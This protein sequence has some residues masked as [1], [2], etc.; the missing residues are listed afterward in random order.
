MEGKEE[1][2]K[3]KNYPYCF[4]EKMTEVDL[5]VW[6]GEGGRDITLR[7]SDKRGRKMNGIVYE[8]S[9]VFENL[10]NSSPKLVMNERE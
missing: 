9:A 5:L 8:K 1:E 10:T 7:K 2:A 3:W 4:R 6:W